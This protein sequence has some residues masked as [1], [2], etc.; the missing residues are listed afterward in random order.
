MKAKDI[1]YWLPIIFM[2]G[3]TLVT[4]ILTIIISTDYKINLPI[5][6]PYILVSMVITGVSYVVGEI[7]IN[8]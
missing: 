6:M 5:Y 1:L 8:K 4:V 2:L 3:S 7:T